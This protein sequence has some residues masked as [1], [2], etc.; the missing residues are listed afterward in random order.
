M[1]EDCPKCEELMKKNKYKFHDCPDCGAKSRTF[2][3]R[4]E[5]KASVNAISLHAADVAWEIV[6]EAPCPIC[7]AS[8]TDGPEDCAA[9]EPPRQCSRR[10]NAMVHRKKG[11]YGRTPRRM[12]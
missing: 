3:Y 1:D 9:G 11:E 7:A 10:K 12:G 5:K 4:D 2:S 8:S 6:K